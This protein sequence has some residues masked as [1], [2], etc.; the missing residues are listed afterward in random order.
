MI[1]IEPREKISR[2]STVLI[3]ILSAVVSL[4]FAAIPLIAAGANPLIAYVEMAKGVFGSIFA[5]SEMLTRATPLIFT[6]LAAAIAFRAKLWNIGAEGQLYL[7]AIAAVTIGSGLFDLPAL[8]LL[9]LII[10]L[11]AGA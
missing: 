9:P 11:G 3:P 4:L 2:S 1:R 6:G 7:G 10:V 5:I 8:L